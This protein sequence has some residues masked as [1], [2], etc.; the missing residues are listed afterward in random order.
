MTKLHNSVLYTCRP[1][2]QSRLPQGDAP[3][4]L[5]A[6]LQSVLQAA[7]DR[8]GRLQEHVQQQQADL[9]ALHHALESSAAEQQD[10]SASLDQ[11]QVTSSKHDMCDH[12]W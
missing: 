2:G 5:D 10:R 3:V 6:L 4:Q 11:M 1:E 12:R 9:Q 7:E 8:E